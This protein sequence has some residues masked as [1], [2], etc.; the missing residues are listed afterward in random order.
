MPS[1]QLNLAAKRLAHS[2]IF[3]HKAVSVGIGTQSK[4][5]SRHRR[6]RRRRRRRRQ[7]TDR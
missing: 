2:Q 1:A 7:V 3:D 6:R 4:S 5:V